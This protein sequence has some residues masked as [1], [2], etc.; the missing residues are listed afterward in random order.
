MIAQVI[1]RKPWI[2][3][4]WVSRTCSSR[5]VRIDAQCHWRTLLS[6]RQGNKT[7]LAPFVETNS[8]TPYS[9]LIHPLLKSDAVTRKTS[10]SPEQQTQHNARQEPGA[11]RQTEPVYAATEVEVEDKTKHQQKPSRLWLAVSLAPCAHPVELPVELG[12]LPGFVRAILVRRVE[13][14]ELGGARQHLH[15]KKSQTYVFQHMYNMHPI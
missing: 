6:P 2:N 4:T 11:N 8:N 10:P 14:A 3:I 7:M 13:S 9:N 15:T 1:N 5:G 12:H